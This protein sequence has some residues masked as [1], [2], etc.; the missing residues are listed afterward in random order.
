MLV[1]LMVYRDWH[2]A[3]VGVFK[4]TVLFS[5]PYLAIL[6]EESP[7]HTRSNILNFLFHRETF[8][9]GEGALQNDTQEI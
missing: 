7:A 1:M 3:C 4:A 5:L 8:V 6:Y 9:N 2:S